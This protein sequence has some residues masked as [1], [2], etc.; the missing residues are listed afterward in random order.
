MEQKKCVSVKQV[1]DRNGLVPVRVT[2]GI[3]QLKRMKESMSVRSTM[4]TMYFIGRMYILV[5]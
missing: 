2:S 3:P 1:G 4:Y 5:N